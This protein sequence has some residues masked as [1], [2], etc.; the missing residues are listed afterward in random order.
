LSLAQLHRNLISH[1]SRE[2]FQSGKPLE[3]GVAVPEN[4]KQ[5]PS[6][7]FFVKIHFREKAD[8]ADLVDVVCERKGI[9]PGKITHAEPPG[10]RE[11]PRIGPEGRPP[12]FVAQKKHRRVM[13]AQQLA[14]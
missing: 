4:L 10:F 8:A 2:R 1:E 13:L 3:C 12:A 11:M 5:A 14:Q 9:R 6:R 7:P